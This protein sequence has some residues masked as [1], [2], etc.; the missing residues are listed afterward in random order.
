MQLLIINLYIYNLF[1]VSLSKSS[2]KLFI[3]KKW[4]V[5][6]DQVSVCIVNN[7]QIS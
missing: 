3:Y 6:Q 1:F 7:L 5:V 4:F 2:V